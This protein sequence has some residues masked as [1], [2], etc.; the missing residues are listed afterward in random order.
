MTLLLYLIIAIALLRLMRVPRR[1]A[2]VLILLP[3]PFVGLANVTVAV[4]P[5]F[6]KRLSLA[7][8]PTRIVHWTNRAPS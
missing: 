2:I 1:A 3:F 8:F 7:T 4:Y 6:L 5:H